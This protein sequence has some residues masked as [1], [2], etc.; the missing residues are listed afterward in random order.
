AQRFEI[1]VADTRDSLAVHLL[2][3]PA[4]PGPLYNRPPVVRGSKS[5]LT[6]LGDDLRFSNAAIGQKLADG[7]RSNDP[8]PRIEGSM[9]IGAKLLYGRPPCGCARLEHARSPGSDSELTA[10]SYHAP[11]F[12]DLLDP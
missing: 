4:V 7:L 1:H 2:K 12:P 3:R 8:L 9:E 10:R 5:L 6:I 11:Q